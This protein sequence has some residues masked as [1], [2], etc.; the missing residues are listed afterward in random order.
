MKKI[1]TL[2]LGVF[3]ALSMFAAPRG[4]QTNIMMK[5]ARFNGQV[6]KQSVE[7]KAPAANGQTIT[8]TSD[9]LVESSY[10]GYPVL[11]GDNGSYEIDVL[12][13]VAEDATDAY[14]TY[15]STNNDIMMYLYDL[16][17]D[18]DEGTEL[19]VIT[20]VYSQ[21][22]EG[23]NHFVADA[24]AED[25]TRYDIDMT[26]EPVSE[27]QY[28]EDAD[29]NHV[30]PTY[31]IDDT[32]LAQYGSVYVIGEDAEYY[33]ILDITL[34]QGA[35]ALV[36]GEYPIATEYAYQTAYS[37]YYSAEY[38]IVPSLAA[39]LI[40]QNGK[41]YYDK[42]W[43]LVSGNVTVNADGSIVVAAVNSL[44]HTISA[45]LQADAS[46]VENVTAEQMSVKRIVDGQLVIERNGVRY[47]AQG[48]E[49]K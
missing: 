6:V 9:N 17:N 1:F 44:E 47:N 19:T 25:G 16:S 32:Y 31:L 2:C 23:L 34:P 8:I 11:Y 40:E 13:F 49:L 22:E 35:T 10:N 14:G 18:E 46:A 15:S 38:G 20:A 12:L 5:S 21:T 41:L 30:F 4:L 43:Y 48:V 36:A 3:V 37:G 29:F 28:D 7:F 27:Y 45:T 39:T 33:L 26:G 42:I 24:M